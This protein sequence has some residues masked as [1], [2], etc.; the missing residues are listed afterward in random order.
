MH[1]ENVVGQARG[2]AIL[3]TGSDVGKSLIVAG[4]CRLLSRRGVRVAP[5]KAQNMAL[6][7]FVTFEGGEIGR[8]QALQAQACGIEPTVDMNPIL[9]KP[10]S[11]SRSQV[12]VRGNVYETLDALAYFERKETLFNIV[13]ECY[14][15]LAREYECVVIEG[16]GSAAEINLRDRDMVNWP[17]VEL[18]D[19]SVV[20]VADIDRGG[21]FAQI[22]GTLDLLAPHE[23]QRVRGVIVNKF[24]G[25]RRL[26]EDGVRMLESRTDLPVLGVVPFLRDLRLDQEDSLDLARSRS[27]QFKPDLINV[28]VV[29]LPRMSNFTDFNTLAAE[30]DVALRFAASPE[31]LRGADVVM[32]P[33]SKNTL[34]DLDY[35][36]TSGFPGALASHVYG[37]SELV[38]ICGGYQMLG[39]AIADPKGLERGGTSR[40]LGFLDVMTELDA[41]KI[42]RQVCATSLL[43]GVEQHKPVRGYEIH[44]GR[45]SRGAVNPCFQIEAS[46][47]LEGNA[48]GDEGAASENDLVWGTSIH[49]LFDQAG[50]RR[51]WLNRARNWKGLPPVSP[52]ESELVTTQLRA[53]L[54]RWA[55][56]LE[57]YVSM[58]AI[59]S[60]FE[61]RSRRGSV[62]AL[63]RFIPKPATR[64]K[65]A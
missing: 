4:F 9:L 20:L 50:F 62:C 52:R 46:E 54:D 13:R 14:A 59:Y 65:P 3:G 10:E 30:K 49:G 36:V 22:I 17:V 34:D 48:R 53:E 51:G 24:R 27:V 40:G 35:L 6:N 5:F 41:P 37:G 43:H 12:V 38:G 16:A 7:S 26:F 55:D 47:T 61:G 58:D 15:R 63:R 8:A 18:A 25:D 33:G 57:Q 39:Q 19:A 64:E 60:V 23:R 2:I 11:D 42:C 44:M 1:W 28:V 31:D 45:I 32:L 56:H 29:L 21:V